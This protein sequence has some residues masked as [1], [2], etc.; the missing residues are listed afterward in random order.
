MSAS[1]SS[2]AAYKND[3]FNLNDFNGHA[4]HNG[5]ADTGGGGEV[6]LHTTMS[7]VLLNHKGNQNPSRFLFKHSTFK[8]IEAITM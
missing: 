3:H 7:E 8:D 2:H 1:G 4:G 5:T 6:D